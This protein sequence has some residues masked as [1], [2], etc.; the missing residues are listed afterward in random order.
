MNSLNRDRWE[1]FFRQFRSA[2]DEDMVGYIWGKCADMGSS[3]GMLM[4]VKRVDMFTEGLLYWH[5]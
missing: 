3:D 1:K 2:S 5:N 4:S